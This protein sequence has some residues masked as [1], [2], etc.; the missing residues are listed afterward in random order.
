MIKSNSKRKEYNGVTVQYQCEFMENYVAE[1]AVNEGK[2][3]QSL[4][5]GEDKAVIFLLEKT[6]YLQL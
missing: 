6:V 1:S 4:K 2:G 3:I 5:F